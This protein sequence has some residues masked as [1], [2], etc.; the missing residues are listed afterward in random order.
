MFL[1]GVVPDIDD[2]VVGVNYG[3]PNRRCEMKFGW[4]PARWSG[5]VKFATGTI[6]AN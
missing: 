1:I 6:M 4:G 2:T 5:Q 3:G